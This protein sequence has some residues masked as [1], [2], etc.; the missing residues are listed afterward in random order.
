[1]TTVPDVR[2]VPVLD[3]VDRLPH[4]EAKT[5]SQNGNGQARSGQHRAHMR[6]HVVRTLDRMGIGDVAGR[7][8]VKHRR[9]VRANIRVGVFLNRE[10]CGGVEAGERDE[11]ALEPGLREYAR[12]RLR[13]ID[14]AGSR[15]RDPQTCRDLPSDGSG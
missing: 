8:T 4:A 6:G 11:P 13:Q 12:Y 1:M 14:E 15:G 2:C 5:A 9:K 10:R 3:Q 7:Q